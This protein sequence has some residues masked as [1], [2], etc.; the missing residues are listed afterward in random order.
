[1]DLPQGASKEGCDDSGYVSY[2]PSGV[3]IWSYS[4]DT[5]TMAEY[6]PQSYKPY[7]FV[8]TA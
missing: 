2:N 5:A 6:T 4:H 8:T 3:G 1:M 7:S